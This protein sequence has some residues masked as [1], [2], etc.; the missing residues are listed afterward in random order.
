[1]FRFDN[2]MLLLLRFSCD[3]IPFTKLQSVPDQLGY[4]YTRTEHKSLPESMDGSCLNLE[5]W[6]FWV[7]SVAMHWYVMSSLLKRSLT[8]TKLEK[9]SLLKTSKGLLTQTKFLP[10]S[11]S[12]WFT[13]CLSKCQWV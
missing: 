8:Q 6:L 3:L 11:V 4:A 2:E 7:S 12:I 5:L 1:M 9:S 10:V 13:C